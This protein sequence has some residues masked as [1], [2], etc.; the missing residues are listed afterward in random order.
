[1]GKSGVRAWGMGALVATMILAGARPAQAGFAAT[2][3]LRGRVTDPAGGPVVGVRVVVQVVASL[4]SAAVSVNLSAPGI[5]YWG[6]RRVAITDANGRYLA[7]VGIPGAI[8]EKHLFAELTAAKLSGPPFYHQERK[9]VGLAGSGTA[10]TFRGDVTLRYRST[11]GAFV[12]GVVRDR[13]TGQRLRRARV[14]VSLLSGNP[15]FYTDG[16]GEYQGVLRMGQATLGPTPQVPS[17]PAIGASGNAWGGNEGVAYEGSTRQGLVFVSG[18]S[19]S[20]NFELPPKAA[21]TA[22]V[23]RVIDGRTGRPLAHA[24]VHARSGW[25]TGGAYWIGTAATDRF[26][27]YRIQVN[28][29]PEGPGTQQAPLKIRTNGEYRKFDDPAAAYRLEEADLTGRIREGDIIEQDFSLVQAS[30]VRSQGALAPLADSL[31]PDRELGYVSW[32]PVDFEKAVRAGFSTVWLGNGSFLG[33]SAQEQVAVLNRASQAGVRTLGFIG[34]D[35]EWVN[36]SRPEQPDFVAD[37][38]RRLTQALAASPSALLGDLKFAFAVDIEPYV[39]DWWTG[40]MAP[41]SDLTEQTLLPI[42]RDY[43]QR[44]PGRVSGDLLT[45]FEPFWWENGHVTESGKTIQNLR[46]SGSDVVASMTYRN[47]AQEIA[48]VSSAIRRRV[49]QKP[50]M[51]FLLG[52]ETKPPGPGIPAHITFYDQWDKI[53]SELMAAISAIPAAHRQ[54]LKGVFIHSGVSGH[55]PG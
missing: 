12:R 43:A 49:E 50:G 42:L 28:L 37:E 5:A 38:Y 51:R 22:V 46:D 30:T 13:E 15:F 21:Q 45:R 10:R 3:T 48:N 23:G 9:F 40:D 27:Q 35:P 7:R 29:F 34:G 17:L 4:E 39:R 8:P 14:T 16:D 24:M 33:L 41:Y 47:T 54:G 31:G 2:A 25:D 53:S 32:K 52:A 44:N 6:Q 11:Y 55:R 1:M 20:F 26:G 36:P 19:Y 18:K